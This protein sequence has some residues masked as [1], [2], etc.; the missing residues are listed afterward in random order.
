MLLQRWEAKIRWK[1]SSHQPGIELT[2]TRSW[3]KPLGWGKKKK[4][5]WQKL[6]AIWKLWVTEDFT[7]I[8]YKKYSHLT[9]LTIDLVLSGLV[10]MG[11]GGASSSS[12][13]GVPGPEFSTG[14]CGCWKDSS[15]YSYVKQTMKFTIGEIQLFP[16]GHI[17]TNLQWQYKQL[18]TVAI[19]SLL[20]CFPNKPLFLCACSTSL[21][22]NAVGKVF[23][24]RSEE[25]RNCSKR[26]ISPFPIAFSSLSEN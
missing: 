17:A 18:F 8:W 13:S 21:L 11:G 7:K 24:K 1:E 6:N 2:T 25:R 16:S 23:R 22:K 12:S 3:V 26:A 4:L 14:F 9:S 20:N 15:K 5:F 10:A 19:S